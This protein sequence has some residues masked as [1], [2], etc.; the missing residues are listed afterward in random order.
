VDEMVAHG[1]VDEVRVLKQ[2]YGC[3][4]DAMTGIGYRQICRFLDGK[5]SLADAITETKKATRLYAKRQMTWFKHDPRIYWISDPQEGF[6][7]V[8]IKM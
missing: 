8:M 6:R 2:K 3:K 4:I 5:S 7:L 1:L